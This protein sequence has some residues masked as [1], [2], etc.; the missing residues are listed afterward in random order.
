MTSKTLLKFF[1]KACNG[2]IEV[3][4]HDVPG[5][6]PYKVKAFVHAESLLGDERATFVAVLFGKAIK[7]QITLQGAIEW[8]NEQQEFVWA[9]G[10]FKGKPVALYVERT[11]VEV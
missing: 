11:L 5:K 7:F 3:S 8:N 2:D 10:P 4:T 6:V 9:K 1:C